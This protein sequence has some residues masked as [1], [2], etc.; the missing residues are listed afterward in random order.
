MMGDIY[1]NA[2]E[3]QI[4][5]GEIEEMTC[6]VCN[7]GVDL[8]LWGGYYDGDVERFKSFL[9]SHGCLT[10]PIPLASAGNLRTCSDVL[11]AFNILKLLGDDKHLCEM[12]FFS[13]TSSMKVGPNTFWYECLD[14]LA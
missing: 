1:G 10:D 3:L 6:Q 12:P 7:D 8:D 2:Q 4:W 14:M 11:G 5:L 9:Q 13:V